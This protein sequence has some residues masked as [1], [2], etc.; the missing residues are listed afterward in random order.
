MWYSVNGGKFIKLTA[1]SNTDTLVYIHL[2]TGY[3]KVVVIYQN[4]GYPNAVCKF[5]NIPDSSMGPVN[6]YSCNPNDDIPLFNLTDIAPSFYNYDLKL[7]SGTIYGYI[8]YH[9][10]TT[11]AGANGLSIKSSFVDL[12]NGNF[13]YAQLLNSDGTTSPYGYKLTQDIKASSS[14]GII[15]SNTINFCTSSVT[16][17]SPCDGTHPWP[18]VSVGVTYTPCQVGIN[19][20]PTGN[21]LYVYSAIRNGIEQPSV[22]GYYMEYTDSTWWQSSGIK[23]SHRFINQL[24]G[25]RLES[26]DITTGIADLLFNRVFNIN[27]Y[28][29]TTYPYYEDWQLLGMSTP[30]NPNDYFNILFKQDAGTA[31]LSGTPTEQGIFD[32]TVSGHDDTGV[33][34]STIVTINVDH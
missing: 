33:F 24:T 28:R 29:I 27:N 22:Q 18:S 7:I 5:E 32:F 14:S 21:T 3:N 10:G 17:N 4:T 23:F 34:S 25:W 20:Q 19:A 1:T 31:T 6:V 13:S 11:S 15:S 12:N 26:M 2:N 8:F 9:G 30:P 16:A